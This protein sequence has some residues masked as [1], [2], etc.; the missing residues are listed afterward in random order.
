MFREF[1]EIRATWVFYLLKNN[2][3][4]NLLNKC[5]VLGTVLAILYVLSLK[6]C[7]VDIATYV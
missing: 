3:N 6:H 5:Y 1:H 2:K 7:Q 4:Y